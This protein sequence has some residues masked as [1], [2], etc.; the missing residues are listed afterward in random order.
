MVLMT[1]KRQLFFIT[2]VFNYL[3]CAPGRIS[4]AVDEGDYFRFC[5]TT[6]TAIESFSTYSYYEVIVSVLRTHSKTLLDFLSF[7]IAFINCLKCQ[8][9]P[10]SIA[11]YFKKILFQ[12]FSKI[13]IQY[14]TIEDS[15][16]LF[17]FPR[18]V[19][20][21]DSALVS[22]PLQWLSSY[23]NAE[24]SWSKALR[25]YADSNTQNASEVADKFRKALEAFFQEF[26]NSSKSL[27]NYKAEYGNYLK[28]KGVPK[29]IAG[30]LEAL[31]QA[32]TNF[33]NNYAKHHDKTGKNILEYLMYQTGNIMRLLITLN[34]EETTSKAEGE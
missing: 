32:Y 17:V 26:F 13:R 1:R 8:T 30:N 19:E 33:M 29:E 3:T 24:K 7:Y 18:G 22:E 14:E 11:E 9:F 15:D 6:N 34:Q 21:F 20:E 12:N 31:L 25:E 10:K 16:G 5:D 28:Q 4:Q 27:E 2:S 23:P